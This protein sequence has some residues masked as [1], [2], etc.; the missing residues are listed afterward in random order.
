MSTNTQQKGWKSQT[1]ETM[2]N[3]KKKK[4]GDK[5]NPKGDLELFEMSARHSTKLICQETS[6]KES[7]EIGDRI[8]TRREQLGISLMICFPSLLF[9]LFI[10]S[11]FLL[12]SHDNC[13]FW[14][15]FFCFCCG[16]FSCCFLQGGKGH[17]GG[18]TKEGREVGGH[19]Y[20]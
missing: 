9:F 17:L 12:F 2:Q 16:V 5:K 6:R 1:A 14:V 7:I 20:G 15:L 19:T 13:F 8:A 10:Y 4:K 11:S 3:V 18:E